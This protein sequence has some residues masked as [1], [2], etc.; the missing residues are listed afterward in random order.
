MIMIYYKYNKC[1]LLYEFVLFHCYIVFAHLLKLLFI[2]STVGN[3][4]NV[5]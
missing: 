1:F 5:H 3:Y 4:M 2:N